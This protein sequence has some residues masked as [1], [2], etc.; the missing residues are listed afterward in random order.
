MHFFNQI[1]CIHAR[2]LVDVL[3]VVGIWLDTT[4]SRLLPIL[5]LQGGESSGIDINPKLSFP[6]PACC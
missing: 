1:G 5:I 2:R 4:F 3:D 6:P